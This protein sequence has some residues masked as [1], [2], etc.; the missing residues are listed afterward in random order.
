M[1]HCCAGVRHCHR[2]LGERDGAGKGSW[3]SWAAFPFCPREGKGV[4]SLFL[5]FPLCRC[6]P[7]AVHSSSNIWSLL[8]TGWGS[9]RTCVLVHTLAARRQRVKAGMWL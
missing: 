3:D 5:Y 6:W 4:N 8:A 7:A 2:E 9:G 1:S